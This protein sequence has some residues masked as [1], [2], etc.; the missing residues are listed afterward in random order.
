MFRPI[1]LS[2]LS[3]AALTFNLGGC[4][5]SKMVELNYEET[6]EVRFRELDHRIFEPGS[7]DAKTSTGEVK[8]IHIEFEYKGKSS[9]FEVLMGPNTHIRYD[10]DH[11]FVDLQSGWVYVWGRYPRVR[12]G[13]IHAG[14][15]GSAMAFWS[16]IENAKTVDR[17]YFI[18][19]STAAWRIESGTP[20]PTNQWNTY[21]EFTDEVL[22]TSWQRVDS[23][24]PKAQLDEMQAWKLEF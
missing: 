19:G 5:H 8:L 23:G 13:R 22:T 15:E 11:S 18:F 2:T 14:A 20:V 3:I 21:A 12:R 7:I 1:L 4:D 6:D 17:V 16:T 10:K 9:S 24:T